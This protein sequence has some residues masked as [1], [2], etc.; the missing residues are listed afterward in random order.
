[1]SASLYLGENSR[2]NVTSWSDAI[3]G[4]ASATSLRVNNLVITTTLSGLDM[5]TRFT[6]A[7][8]LSG[9]QLA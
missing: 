8:I 4:L 2:P 7:T 1:M 9:T 3:Q 5:V 6:I